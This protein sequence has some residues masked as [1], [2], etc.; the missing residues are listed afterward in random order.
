MREQRFRFLGLI[1]SF[2]FLLGLSLTRTGWNF[3][4]A[5]AEGRSLDEALV[6]IIGLG[7][8][9]FSSEGAGY[10]INSVVVFVWNIRGGGKPTKG[11][12]SREWENLSYHL[13]RRVIKEY[14]DILKRR[15]QR[16]D[17]LFD[18]RVEGYGADAFFSYFWQQAPEGLVQWVSRRHTALFTGWGAIVAASLGFLLSGVIAL[19]WGLGWTVGNSVM[20]ALVVVFAVIIWYNAWYAQVEARQSIDL[21]L[22]GAFNPGMQRA[23][24]NISGLFSQAQGDE[25]KGPENTTEAE[26]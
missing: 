15:K 21:W 17:A 24:R 5:V 13:E 11:G 25:T 6:A 14:H 19:G 18:R 12:Y 10:L 16:K 7:V 8:V 26:R 3:L 22:A 4:S 23:L 20:M 2:V 9:F 1:F